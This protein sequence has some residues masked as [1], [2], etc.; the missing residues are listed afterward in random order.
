MKLIY[1]DPQ[2]T[3][4]RVA[5][6]NLDDLWHLHNLID[7]GDVVEGWTFRTRDIKD[8]KLR[9][10]KVGKERMKLALKVEQVEFAEF[11][12]RLRI[13]GTIAE[14]QQ[15]LGQH[16]TLVVEADPRNDVRILKARGFQDHHWERIKEA[17]EAAKRPLLVIVAMDDEETQVSL[18][19]QYGIQN[20]ANLKGRP[21]G[22]MYEQTGEKPDEYFGTV[23][24]AIKQ[25]RPK[26]APCVVVGP[27]FSRERFLEFIRARDPGFLKG[28]VTEGTAQAGQVGVQEALKRGIVERIQQTQQVARDTML[29]EE[30]FAEIGKD[31]AATYGEKEVRASLQQGAVRLLLITDEVMRLPAGEELL[32]ISK[33]MGAQSHIVAV[34]HE[35]GKKLH[36]LGG[37]SALLRYKA[38]R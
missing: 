28:V 1:K 7:V 30:L 8:D 4:V 14:G 12:D 13:H 23:F 18:L 36:A 21:S 10:E 35:A 26:D 5:P 33:A 6:E 16:H 15:D 17:G 25:V 20:M 22:K 29:V 9:G 37:I 11:A 24:A 34:T 27:G 38:A 32:R 19:R 3:E 2:R 31:G